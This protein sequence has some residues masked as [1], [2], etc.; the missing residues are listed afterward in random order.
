VWH[1][2]NRL[3]RHDGAFLGIDASIAPLF[4]GQSS[5]IHMINRFGLSFAESVTTD[6]YIT[7]T[8]YL[9]Q[10]NPKPVGLCGIMFPCLEDFGLAAE[11][12]TGNFPVE[13]NIYLALHSGLGLDTYPLGVDED[14]VH[15]LH[16][17]RLL[18]GLAKKYGKALSARFVSD[19]QAG[20]GDR[21]D[22]G[23]PYLDDVTIRPLRNASAKAP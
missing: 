14:P 21:T 9:R 5:L 17:F 12:E 10:Y 6:I 2:I 19:G 13:R 3:L 22:F 8:D 23:H 7:M 20:V 4:A 1:E 15:L 18:Q 11:Y 16:I